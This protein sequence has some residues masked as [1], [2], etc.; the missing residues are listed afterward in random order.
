MPKQS[1][2]RGITILFL[3][4]KGKICKTLEL[5]PLGPFLLIKPKTT[6]ILSSNLSN[7]PLL[8]F[9]KSDSVKGNFD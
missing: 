1:E 4:V 9:N 8:W 6:M 5:G 3:F 2:K 7:H